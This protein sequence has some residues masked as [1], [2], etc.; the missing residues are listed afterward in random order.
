MKDIDNEDC[1]IAKH[2]AAHAVMIRELGFEFSQ[3]IDLDADT[4]AG[5]RGSVGYSPMDY[6][7]Q[8][9]SRNELKMNILPALAGPVMDAGDEVTDTSE[10]LDALDR[11]PSD[12]KFVDEILE[13]MDLHDEERT[14]FLDECLL[15]TWNALRCSTVRGAVHALAQNL[16]DRRHMSAAELK[17][18]IDPKLERNSEAP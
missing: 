1:F 11:Q 4:G 2:E 3:G 5:T 13:H 14:E 8:E 17:E 16:I 12:K 10:L 18:F 6:R 7:T 15:D 9:L